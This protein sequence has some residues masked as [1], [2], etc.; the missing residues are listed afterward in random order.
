[1]SALTFAVPPSMRHPARLG[2]MLMSYNLGRILSYMVAGALVAG[3][4]VLGLVRIP[5][6]AAHLREGLLCIT[7]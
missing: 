7:G 6:L 3:F 1:M 5:G 4:G 2:G